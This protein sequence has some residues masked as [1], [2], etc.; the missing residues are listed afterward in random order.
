MRI[1]AI[2]TDT[3]PGSV[4]GQAAGL[5]LRHR[6]HAR[7]EDRIRQAKATGLRNL[8]CRA[9]NENQAWLE[10]VLTAVDLV[11]WTKLICFADAAEL[12]RCEIAAFRYRVLHVA[13]RL[14]RGSPPDPAPHRQDLALGGSD[15]CRFCPATA[16]RSID[17]EHHRPSTTQDPENRP[18]AAPAGTPAT[19]RSNSPTRPRARHT[20]RSSTGQMKEGG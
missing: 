7:V 13:A 5:E 12:A 20:P 9:F 10:V 6:Q 14:T 19:H 3:P 18:P 2:L 8:P 4:P 1:T 15:R 17:P 16:P 11:A